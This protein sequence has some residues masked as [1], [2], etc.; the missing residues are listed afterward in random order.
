MNFENIILREKRLRKFE[1]EAVE[2]GNCPN[3]TKRAMDIIR[4]GD[5]ELS[6]MKYNSSVHGCNCKDNSYGHAKNCKH[7]IAEIMQHFMDTRFE[8]E[9]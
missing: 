5:L 1:R 3:R 2:A 7:V 8:E 9:E 6:R 4:R